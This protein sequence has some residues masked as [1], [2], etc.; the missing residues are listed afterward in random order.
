MISKDVFE[1]MSLVLDAVGW[2]C[3]EPGSDSFRYL[4]ECYE[5]YDNG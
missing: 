5:R 2:F 4:K 3:R 1:L